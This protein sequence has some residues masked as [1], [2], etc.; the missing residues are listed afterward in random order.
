MGLYFMIADTPELIDAARHLRHRHFAEERPWEPLD[1]GAIETDGYDRRA[2]HVLVFFE[3]WPVATA[4]L[5]LGPDLPLKKYLPDYQLSEGAMEVSRLCMPSP[6]AGHPAL[7]RVKV[8]K[9]LAAGLDYLRNLHQA[10]E[11]L[12]LMRPS[13]QRVLRRAGFNMVCCGPVVDCKGRRW[14]MRFE[15]KTSAP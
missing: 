15:G 10:Q 6:K 1:L 7:D 4:R 14:L 11:V 2:A 3:E 12:A 13:L 5:C 8:C 9:F